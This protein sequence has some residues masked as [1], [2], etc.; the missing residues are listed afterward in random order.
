MEENKSNQF[1][2]LYTWMISELG[3][4]GN[5]LILYAYLYRFVE[6]GMKEIHPA[7]KNISIATGMSQVTIQRGLASLSSKGYIRANLRQKTLPEIFMFPYS[8]IVKKLQNEVNKK[9]FKMKSNT[10]NCSIKNFKM[11]SNTS[12]CSILPINREL[13]REFFNRELNREEEG[14][15]E[16]N[17]S[18]PSSQSLTDKEQAIIRKCFNEFVKKYPENRIG[19]KEILFCD[20]ASLDLPNIFDK[21]MAT[22]Q[23]KLNNGDWIED[24]SKYCPMAKK[25]IAEAYWLKYPSSVSYDVTYSSLVDESAS[26]KELQKRYEAIANSFSI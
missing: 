3:L 5:E 16:R 13:N 21:M 25:F 8:E 6:S 19:K 12:N 4:S 26:Q 22:L 7:T 10:S 20:F 18:S 24:N 1:Y 9:N 11:K 14:K 15:E 23:A 17:S 2:K